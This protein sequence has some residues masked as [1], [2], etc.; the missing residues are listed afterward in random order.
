MVNALHEAERLGLDT[1]QVFTKNQQ[2]WKAKPL[3]PAMVKEWRAELARL[4]W[5]GRV[6]SHA[7]YL[8]NLASCNDEL[9]AKSIDLMTDEIERCEE[10]GIAFL[11]HHPGSH[12]NWSLEEGLARIGGAYKELFKRTKGYKIVSCLED[13]AGGGNTIGGPFEQLADLRSRIIAATGQPDRIGF[14]LDSCHMHAF[15]YDLSTRAGAAKA[16]GEF[17]GACG[18]ANLRVWHLNDSKGKLA[19]RLDRHQHIGEGW[20]G[21]GA[22]AHSGEGVFDEK[23]LKSSGFAEIMA[24]P[25]FAGVPKIMET[26]KD[27]R[28]N[29][30]GQALDAMNLARLKSLLPGEGAKPGGGKAGRG[31][32]RPDAGA[33]NLR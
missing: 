21:G 27:D 33:S 14:C 5:Q 19:S 32:A 30:D 17:D 6:V 20:I 18:L 23:A 31:R 2:Q 3:D 4:G 9:L 7:S 16:L 8:I 11:V 24:N 25:A 12:V 28:E 29:E 10:L 22:K 13:T 1:V 15:G 26:P